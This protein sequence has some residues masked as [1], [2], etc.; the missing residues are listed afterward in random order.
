MGHFLPFSTFYF[1]FSRLLIPVHIIGAGLLLSQAELLYPFFQSNSI[2]LLK[3]QYSGLSVISKFLQKLVRQGRYFRFSLRDN[4]NADFQSFDYL[5]NLKSIL[6]VV[7]PAEQKDIPYGIH[8]SLEVYGARRKLRNFFPKHYRND[9]LS[10]VRPKI[11]NLLE[12]N[13][14]KSILL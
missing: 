10:F 11:R 1:E 5:I 14:L 8:A 9:C 12:Y 7:G 2:V 4:L 13:F 6:I 3:V